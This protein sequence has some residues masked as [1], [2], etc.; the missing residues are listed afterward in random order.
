MRFLAQVNYKNRMF[1]V[2]SKL[3]F[4]SNFP[5]VPPIFS[6][7]NTE[8]Q[9]LQVNPRYINFLLPDKT[10]EVKIGSSAYFYNHK[11]FNEL[12]NE[13]LDTLSRH[14]PF[15]QTP[16][17]NINRN[18]TVYFDLRYNNPNTIFPFDMPR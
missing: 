1:P 16:N 18:Y 13:F 5:K 2:L 10:F 12:F 11:N 9:K 14:F 15:F 8:E 4:P 3:N 7:V 6:I 17:P